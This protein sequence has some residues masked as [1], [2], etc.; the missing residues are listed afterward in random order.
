MKV[1]IRINTFRKHMMKLLTRH[2]GKSTIVRNLEPSGVKKILISRP[3]HR[4]GNMLLITPLVQEVQDTFPN[5]TIDLFVGGNA[6]SH[7]FRN[8]QNIGRIIELPRRPFSNIVKYFRGWLLLRISRYDF[9]INI[10]VHSSSGRLSI[11]LSRSGYKFFGEADTEYGIEYD[12]YQHIAKY[13]IYNLRNYLNRIG[14]V[15]PNNPIPDLSLNLSDDELARGAKLL[16]TIILKG[17]IT[18]C[19]FTNATGNKCY[20]ELWWQEFY[21]R[22]EEEFPDVNFIEMLPVENISRLGFRIP[23]FYSTDLR[24]MG[25]VIANTTL[26][27]S[28]DG[29]VMHLA[30]AT[31][32]PTI[33]LFSVTREQIYAPYNKHSLAINTDKVNKNEMLALIVLTLLNVC[34]DIRKEFGKS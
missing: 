6:A 13:P 32:T 30:S 4:L 10:N 34:Y 11:A 8:N 20:S 26:F 22:L 7:I 24:E 9:A 1:P 21:N 28:A 17:K 15:Q 2:I 23:R 31:G 29:G 33:G 5:C 16:N 19:L 27:I 3:N 12:D 18:I 14:F 25:A